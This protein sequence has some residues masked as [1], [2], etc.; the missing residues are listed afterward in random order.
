MRRVKRYVEDAMVEVGILDQLGAHPH[1][2]LSRASS[3]QD[4]SSQDFSLAQGDAR[5]RSTTVFSCTSTFTTGLNQSCPN[6]ASSLV[7]KS[8]F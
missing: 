5:D 7:R 8:R 4:I 6:L 3:S 2:G 1:P